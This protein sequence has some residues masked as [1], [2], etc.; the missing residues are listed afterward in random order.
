MFLTL[1]LLA[2]TDKSSDDPRTFDSDTAGVCGRVRGANGILLYEDGGDDLHAPTEPPDDVHTTGV[3]GPVGSGSG[4]IAAYGGNVLVS[5]DTGCN[6]EE[7][8]NL[9][10]GGDWA[11]VAAGTRVYAFDRASSTGA[12]SDDLGETWT[13]FDS[14]EPFLDPPVW[15][16]A[17]RLRGVQARGV[18]TSDDGGTAG[19]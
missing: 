4:M 5:A 19:R 18:A 13:P 3:T 11:L 14:V 8:G 15:D 1:I 17:S 12:R 2:C 7:A 16:G 10:A 9:P 6:W